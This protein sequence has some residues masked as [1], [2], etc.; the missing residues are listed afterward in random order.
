MNGK[1]EPASFDNRWCVF[2]QD[3]PSAQYLKSKGITRVILRSDRLQTDL[4]RVLYDYQQNGLTLHICK[5]ANTLPEAMNV[6]KP[7]LQAEWAYRLKTILK[8]KRNAA[9]GFG[10]QIP[11]AYENGGGGGVYYRMG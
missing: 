10:G 6:K 4:A 5:T 9:G 2:P 7:G 1:R 3:M 8:L 11:A